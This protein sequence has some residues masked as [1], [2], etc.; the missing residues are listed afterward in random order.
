MF[1]LFAAPIFS[2]H[3]ETKEGV[4]ELMY[5]KSLPFTLCSLFSTQKRT[6][7]EVVTFYAETTQVCRLFP[8]FIGGKTGNLKADFA[9][10]FASRFRECSF[11]MPSVI[12]SNS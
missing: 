12:S 10:A 7:R 4:C 5:D 1:V 3:P 9:F 2:P 6:K 8:E 11:S